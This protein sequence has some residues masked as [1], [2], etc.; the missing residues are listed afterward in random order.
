M[1]KKLTQF[2]PNYPV[3]RVPITHSPKRPELLQNMIWTFYVNQTLGSWSINSYY[4]SPQ[5]VT[6][7]V[8]TEG[9]ISQGHKKLSQSEH[10]CWFGQHL[11]LSPNMMHI[12]STLSQQKQ[13][14]FYPSH[15]NY[16]QFPYNYKKANVSDFWRLTIHY[17]FLEQETERKV[18][19]PVSVPFCFH[20]SAIKSVCW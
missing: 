9:N 3:E 5:S 7:G 14:D 11:N 15:I 12:Y 13:L 2:P 10:W 4:S 18:N 6:Q 19:E 8:R 1:R 17:S 20:K 16:R